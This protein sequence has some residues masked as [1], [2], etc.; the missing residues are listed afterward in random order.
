MSNVKDMISSMAVLSEMEAL[1]KDLQD[2]HK[3]TQDYWFQYTGDKW[4]LHCRD[5]QGELVRWPCE[6]IK[7]INFYAG[8]EDE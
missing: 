5:R 1:I 4:C 8:D 3:M 6:T 7:T 2:L